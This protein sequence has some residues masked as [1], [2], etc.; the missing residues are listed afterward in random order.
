MKDKFK[1]ELNDKSEKELFRDYFLSS[2]CWLFEQKLG[3]PNH[4]EMYDRFKLVIADGL[5]V[6]PMNIIMVGS[7]KTGF[8]VAPH[9]AFKDFA[10]NSDIDIVVVSD[11]IYKEAWEA[12]NE[13]ATMKK[14]KRYQA[15]TSEIFRHFVSLKEVDTDVDFFERWDVKVN[16]FKKNL[17]LI[18]DVDNEINYRIYESWEW[19]DTYHLNGLA[20][21]KE[22]ECN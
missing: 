16:N 15:I 7:A 18:F 6:H 17:Q 14:V 22:S 1:L 21:L 5:G 9:K 13:L 2:K 10:D 3:H 11:K 12:F 20:K 8:S 4:V 19:V